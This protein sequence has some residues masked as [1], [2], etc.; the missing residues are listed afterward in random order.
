M[1]EDAAGISSLNNL[2]ADLKSGRRD[3]FRYFTFDLMYCEGCDLTKATLLDRKNL[4]QAITAGLSA[5]LPIRFSE[6]LATDGP[7]MLPHM[8][9]AS[10][11]KASSPSAA[12]CPTGAGAASTG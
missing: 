11:L 2:Q 9:A 8:R 5:D 7:T 4:L 6:H 3:R 12:T 1:V 10:A